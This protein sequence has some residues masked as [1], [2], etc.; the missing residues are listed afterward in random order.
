MMRLHNSFAFIAFLLALSIS[1]PLSINFYLA[2]LPNM[3]E[4]LSTNASTIQQTVSVYLIGFAGAQLIVGPLSDRFGRRP[5]LIVGYG[6]FS[7][8][9]LLCALATDSSVLIAGR[10]IQSLGGCSGVLI[11]RAI[12]RDVYPA[13]KMGRIMSYLVTGFSI[14]PLIA[15]AIGGYIGIYYGW[16]SL[17]FILAGFGFSLMVW[18]WLGFKETNKNLNP[19][20]TGLWKIVSNYAFL[21]NNPFFLCYLIVISTSVA[22]ILTYTSASSFV[23]IEVL[24][25]PAQYYGL[26]FSIS[27][28]GMFLGSLLSAKLSHHFSSEQAIWYG[29]LL[30]LCGGVL[31]AVLPWLGVVSVLTLVGSMFIYALGNGVVMP[32]AMALAIM[33]FPKKAGAAAAL[34]GCCQSALGAACGYVAG[35]LFDH[36]AIPMTSTI[37]L[38]SLLAFGGVLYA[39]VSKR[40]N[41]ESMVDIPQ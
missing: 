5:I 28:L 14:A 4:S 19:T 39:R 3:A 40:E 34:I 10:F 35:L 16:R 15:P 20:A 37:G 33:P 22:G 18:S 32:S 38:L 2:L 29:S 36:S 31:L 8:A 24:E 17:F 27:A 26:L 12:V 6:L 41:K 11:S 30:L 13:D 25:V 23:L 7:V 21:L 1:G 9:S